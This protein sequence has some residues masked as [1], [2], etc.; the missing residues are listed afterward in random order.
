MATRTSPLEERRHVYIRRKGHNPDELRRAARDPVQAVVDA[1]QTGDVVADG[2]DNL[3]LHPAHSVPLR[4]PDDV[5]AC[6]GHVSFVVII[7]HH[8][9]GDTRLVQTPHQTQVFVRGTPA[10]HENVLVLQAGWTRHVQSCAAATGSWQRA[11]N[12]EKTEFT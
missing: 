10:E 11:Y 3:P 9:H 12:W 7:S 2:Y 6:C 5:T 8:P 1:R 4:H